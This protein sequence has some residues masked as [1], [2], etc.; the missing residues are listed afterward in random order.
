[1]QEFLYIE[2]S[3]VS[4]NRGPLCISQRLRWAGHVA[5]IEEM[6]KGHKFLQENLKEI[7]TIRRPWRRWECNI[8]MNLRKIGCEGKN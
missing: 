4:T 2:F 3:Y 8:I 6:R 5:R 1:M 7:E